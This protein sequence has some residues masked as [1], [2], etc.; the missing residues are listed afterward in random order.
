MNDQSFPNYN[1]HTG[2][3][4]VYV[5]RAQATYNVIGMD[6]YHQPYLPF[7]LTTRALFQDVNAHL[8]DDDVVVVNAVKPD[9]DYRLVNVLADA[10]RAVFPQV[11]ILDV[12]SF[13]NSVTIGAKQ[14]VGVGAANSVSDLIILRAAETELQ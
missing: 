14:P 10:M 9:D 7:H 13:G 8:D 1:V 4:R 6:A 5:N 3:S 2:D 11:F 12:P